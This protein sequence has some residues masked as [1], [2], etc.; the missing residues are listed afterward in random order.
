MM[1]S[2]HSGLIR[3]KQINKTASHF[4]HPPERPPAKIRSDNM[5]KATIAAMAPAPL[6]AA[7]VLAPQ[8]AADQNSF[9]TPSRNISCEMNSRQP[10]NMPDATYCQS[11]SPPQSAHM[12]TDGTVTICN[13]QSCLGNPGIDTPILGYGQSASIGPFNC[14]SDTGGVT[15]TVASGRGFTISNSGIQ[16]L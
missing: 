11:N 4:A 15:C 3:R 6:L 8:A 2:R 9:L 7:L 10:Y 12:S 5:R 16:W 13:G 14:V 1:T